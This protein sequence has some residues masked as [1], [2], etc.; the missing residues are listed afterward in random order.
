MSTFAQFAELPW[1]FFCELGTVVLILLPRAQVTFELV[2]ETKL[3]NLVHIFVNLQKS[4]LKVDTQKSSMDSIKV[5]PSIPKQVHRC[6]SYAHTT[7]AAGGRRRTGR[8]VHLEGLQ[9]SCTPP[10]PPRQGPAECSKTRRERHP[11][12]GFK[13]S[14]GQDHLDHHIS[15]WVVV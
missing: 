12:S 10:P 2:G 11:K 4:L 6:Q 5:Y 9:S 13:H 1:P 14:Q 7:R 3:F 8:V 15:D